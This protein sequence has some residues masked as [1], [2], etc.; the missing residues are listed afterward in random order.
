M[1]HIKLFKFQLLFLISSLTQI[2]NGQKDICNNNATFSN[3][4]ILLQ[5]G[6]NVTVGFNLTLCERDIM[7]SVVT[8]SS[9]NK[10]LMQVVDG[11]LK[12]LSNNLLTK[13]FAEAVH[14]KEQSFVSTFPPPFIHTQNKVMRNVTVNVTFHSAHVGGT[15]VTIKLFSVKELLRQ[16]A[17]AANVTQL[18]KYDYQ[19]KNCLSLMT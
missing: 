6:I 14:S 10:E 8:F 5:K 11:E 13:T 16:N 1:K 7:D 3:Y 9:Q 2:S 19:L 18:A 12:L 4:P 15:A 17:L